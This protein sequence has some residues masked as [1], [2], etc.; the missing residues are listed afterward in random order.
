MVIDE[1]YKYS[2]PLFKE[3]QDSEIDVQ[4]VVHGCSVRYEN[5]NPTFY[6]EG[7]IPKT[8]PNDFI[9]FFF[10]IGYISKEE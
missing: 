4:G 9:D 7:Y 2:L 5:G 10:S 8:F 6:K 1:S 3:S